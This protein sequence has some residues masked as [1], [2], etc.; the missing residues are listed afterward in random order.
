MY[1]FH[2]EWGQAV[3]AT[4]QSVFV[5]FE[6]GQTVPIHLEIGQAVLIMTF[7]NSH[8]A[9]ICESLNCLI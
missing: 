8:V 1:C 4:G 2:Y 9:N 6:D 5:Q 7:E 3:F